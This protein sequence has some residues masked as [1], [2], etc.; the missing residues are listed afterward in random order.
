MRA[1]PDDLRIG[2]AAGRIVRAAVAVRLIS[3]RFAA[4]TARRAIYALAG[5]GRREIATGLVAEMARIDSDDI[6]LVCHEVFVGMGDLD[7][8]SSVAG[9]LEGA[10]ASIDQASLRADR[11]IARGDLGDAMV[12]LGTSGTA[13]DSGFYRRKIEVLRRSG[14]ARDLLSLLESGDEHVGPVSAS[15]V[16]FDALWLLG[17]PHDAA[18]AILVGTNEGARSIDVL[19]RIRAGVSAG[20]IDPEILGAFLPLD[21]APTSRADA[22]WGAVVLSELDRVDDLITWA[23]TTAVSRRLGP[24][25]RL[26]LARAQYVRRDFA[27]ARST[28]STVLGTAQHW[29]AEKLESRMLLEEGR[30]E[31]AL[32]NRRAAG[33]LGPALDE[34]QYFAQLQLGM[35]DEAFAAYLH[36]P[37]VRRLTTLFGD[38]AE[39]LPT[40]AVGRRFVIAQNGPGDEILMSATYAALVEQSDEVIATCDPRLESLLRRSFPDVK[41]IPV[42]RLASKQE[43]GFLAPHKPAR[44]DGVFFDLLTSEAFDTAM[45]AD[46][47]VLGRSLIRL[48]SSAAPYDPYLRSDPNL[49]AEMQTR[50]DPDAI[51]V[52]WRSEFG[53]AMRSIHYFTAD[54]LAPFAGLGRPMICLQ[55]DVTDDER[56]TLVRQFGDRISFLDD[57]DLRN[58]F[59][60]LAAVVASCAVVVG[61]GTTTVELAAAVGT[62][63]I[64]LLPNNHGSW[65]RGGDGNSDYWHETM[66]VAC[67]DDPTDRTVCIARAVELVRSLPQSDQSIG[68]IRSVRSSGRA[69]SSGRNASN[70]ER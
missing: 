40:E 28:I 60:T 51:G 65:R 59:E 27:A 26:Y 2:G 45:A 22:D 67:S 34:V 32:A 42:E 11:A 55:H 50:I 17:R 61:A 20:A 16:R 6:R 41:L 54:D 70:N 39:L 48:T 29:D 23:S 25:G 43:P 19:R 63:T 44:A 38:R 1:A 46:R 64:A 35:R 24:T 31:A 9:H 52:V 7:A 5:V 18:T 36:P 4:A 56:D 47:V 21:H 33:R 53:D 8:A 10:H 62:P 14:R 13:H 15:I 49:V 66:R 57:L 37:D 30:F 3:P 68:A 58:D 12:A 69:A